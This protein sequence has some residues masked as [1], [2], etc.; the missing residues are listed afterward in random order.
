MSEIIITCDSTADL[1]IEMREKYN[2]KV[3]PLGVTLGDTT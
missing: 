3:I 2:I 1:P